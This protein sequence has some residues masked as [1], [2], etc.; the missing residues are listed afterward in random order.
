MPKRRLLVVDD[1][2]A[3]REIAQISLQT[4]GGWD[5][6]VAG[7]G[8]EALA[9]AAADPPDAILLDVM[10]PGMDGPETVARLRD[11]PSMRH[12][13]VVLLTAKVQPAER[14][15]LAQLP[16]VLGV[17]AKPFDPLTLAAQVAEIVGWD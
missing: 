8:T 3:I 1:E 15:R 12:I 9:R 2:P 13:A 11:Q 16:G 5:A 4:I 14:G 10:M 7:S 6:V 17:I